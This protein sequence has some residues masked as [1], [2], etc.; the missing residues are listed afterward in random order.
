MMSTLKR[1]FFGSLL[2]PLLML[3]MPGL[4]AA[5]PTP[6]WPCPA[7]WTLHANGICTPDDISA[8]IPFDNTV[9]IVRVADA[10]GGCPD[11]WTANANGICTPN[12]LV[13]DIPFDH[14]IG[15]FILLLSPDAGC[16]DGW[17]AHAGGI[18]TPND[19]M[20][21]VPFDNSMPLMLRFA[22]VAPVDLSRWSIREA[23]AD[24]GCEGD[25]LSAGEIMVDQMQPPYIFGAQQ[26]P[27]P[28]PGNYC[29][30]VT[31]VGPTGPFSVVVTVTIVDETPPGVACIPTTN[32]SGKKVPTAPAKGAQGQ[33]QDGFY[34]LLA[35]DIADPNPQVF[36]TD[37]ATGTVFGPFASGTKI[38]LT[39]APGADPKIKPGPGV[40][41]W[42]IT[43]PGDAVVIAIDASG[44]V[45]KTS[46][47]VPPPPK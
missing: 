42:H 26:D 16:P 8:E 46:C 27:M 32:P 7:D 31:G 21:E 14:S 3:L 44:N 33:N 36:L 30:V 2:V 13:Q 38:K 37:S 47:L 34:Q 17:T 20:L 41:D 29:V 1:V 28:S 10:N 11:G 24:G 19:F 6:N 22:N 25:V 5:D 15:L 23:D 18:C 35:R 4:A 45:A 12:T 9:A 40:I 39:Q 43:I